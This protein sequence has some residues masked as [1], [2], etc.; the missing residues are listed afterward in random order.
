MTRSLPLPLLAL[1]RAAFAIGTTEFVIMG[2]LAAIAVDLRVDLPDAGLIVTG[3]RSA[4]PSARCPRPRSR[5]RLVKG[6]CR[7]HSLGLRTV[8]LGAWPSD[9]TSPR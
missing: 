4:S 2:L 8:L 1:A 3:W 5:P 9:R 7:A 6:I